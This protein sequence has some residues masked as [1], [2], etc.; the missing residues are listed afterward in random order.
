MPEYHRPHPI[1]PLED[2][3]QMLASCGFDSEFKHDPSEINNRQEFYTLQFSFNGNE[4]IAE[5]KD[6]LRDII[7]F[8]PQNWFSFNLSVELGALQ[9]L[10]FRR[11]VPRKMRELLRSPYYKSLGQR[12]GGRKLKAPMRT[13]VSGHFSAYECGSQLRSTF[14]WEGRKFKLF[15]IMP[16][17]KQLGLWSVEKAGDFLVRESVLPYSKLPDRNVCASCRHYP[18]DKSDV[19]WK[20]GLYAMQD[21]LIVDRLIRHLSS[22]FDCDLT[23]VASMGG[24]AAAH[25]HFPKRNIHTEYGTEIDPDEMAVRESLFA[26]RNECFMNGFLGEAYYNDIVSLYPTAALVADAFKIEGIEECGLEEL[27]ISTDLSNKDYGW[28]D[29]LFSTSDTVWGLATRKDGRN[30]YVADGTVRGVRNT[31]DLAAGAAKVLKAY[32]CW[33]PVYNDSDT[34]DRYEELYWR[35]VNKQYKDDTE[36][37]LIKGVLNAATGK[38]GQGASAKSFISKHT[39]FPA[40]SAVLA[41]SHLMMANIMRQVKCRMYGMDTDSIM[42]DKDLTGE[43]YRIGR[44][45]VTMDLKNHGELAYIRSKMYVWMD[46]SDDPTFHAWH[47]G[48]E[49]LQK[50][51]ASA[52][53]RQMVPHQTAKQRYRV[54]TRSRM[55]ALQGIPLGMWFQSSVTLSPENQMRLMICDAKRDRIDY[56][57]LN[58]IAERRC[59]NSKPFA[60]HSLPE[61]LS[62][63]DIMHRLG[64]HCIP[65]S[66]NPIRI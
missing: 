35:K 12:K 16:V 17:C 6:E 34:H 50:V 64:I 43:Y 53:E 37:K 21:A 25:L 1:A 13:A 23:K 22:N 59:E 45:P 7:D 15:D 41:M 39:N 48:R 52:Y 55:D 61:V 56:N 42:A 46:G 63:T 31:M 4:Y 9:M 8:L 27:E 10:G 38:L 49:D 11:H 3:G 26:G 65:D 58:L 60:A 54:T 29:G 24:V 2:N 14:N 30:Y 36:K 47:Y 33:K 44:Y 51:V 28:V 20:C 66:N 57:S 19:R 40:Y 5:N 18:C 62:K 32:R